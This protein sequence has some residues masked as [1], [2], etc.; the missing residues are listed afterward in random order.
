MRKKHEISF[1]LPA[2]NEEHHIG[3][4]I[5]AIKAYTPPRISSEI[6]VV[7]NGST[8]G[9]VEI[10]KKEGAIV[11]QKPKFTIGSLRNYGVSKAIN[12]TIVFLDADV[13]LKPS[14]GDH[15]EQTI[16][17]LRQDGDIIT[18][19]TCG[20]RDNP[21]LVEKCWWGP[22]L[23]RKNIPYINSGHMIMTK[24]FFQQL[25]GFNAKLKS[26]EDPEL[27][28][29]AKK[30]GARIVNNS[31]LAVVHAGYPRTLKDFYRRERWH[32]RG[33][34][35]SLHD[36]LSSKV[37]LLALFQLSL[38]IASIFYALAT[39]NPWY[40]LIYI[41]FLLSLSTIAAYHRSKK[42]NM[43]MFVCVV[44]AATYF[45]ARSHA[46]LDIAF[47][48]QFLRKRSELSCF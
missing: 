18:G 40:L 33:V 19:S 6:I 26:G 37:T 27:C 1:I 11:Y 12:E 32:G 28:F 5:K 47:S 25:G 10:A 8:D 24:A 38:L 29:R 30:K 13:Y 31:K 4:V 3:G 45:I 20:L 14:W 23:K 7:D 9:T 46:F 17:R 16:E 35:K 36:V 43:C 22:R 48:R 39:L 15:I 21:G 42:L 2:L 34:F 44:I 41:L